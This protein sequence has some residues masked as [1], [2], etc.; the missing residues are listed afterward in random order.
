MSIASKLQEIN[1]IK[2][3]IKTALTNKGVSMSSVAFKDY[4]S[5][6]NEIKIYKDSLKSV[7]KKRYQLSNSAESTKYYS[8]IIDTG[9]NKRKGTFVCGVNL[10][11]GYVQGSNDQVEW[12]NVHTASTFG[13]GSGDWGTAFCETLTSSSYRY[14]R[15]MYSGYNNGGNNYA[16]WGIFEVA[17]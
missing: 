4:P 10:S 14:Y 15:L 2:Q 9:N 17:D 3:N 8:D 7:Y 16:F 6:V 5:K 1:T 12:V 11:N 13:N